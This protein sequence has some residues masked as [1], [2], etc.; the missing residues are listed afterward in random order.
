MYICNNNYQKGHEFKKEESGRLRG[1][2]GRDENDINT[3]VGNL[4][5]VI[6]RIQIKN[7]TM[8]ILM[9]LRDDFVQDRDVEIQS[10]K[11]KPGLNRYKSAELR[12]PAST[13]SPKGDTTWFSALVPPPSTFSL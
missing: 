11:S 3:P 2:R 9:V 7:K 5:K 1:E 6:R 10:V 8:R 4:K 12:V 13:V